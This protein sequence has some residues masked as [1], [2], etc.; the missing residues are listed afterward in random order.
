[1]KLVAGSST[2]GLSGDGGPATSAQIAARVSW[3]DSL[4]NMY[5]PDADNFRI[6]KIDP[7]GIITTFGGNATQSTAGRSGPISSAMFL[8]PWSIVGDTAGSVMFICDQRYVWKYIFATNIIAVYAHSPD[9]PPGMGGDDGLATSAT[10]NSPKRIWLTTSGDLY[11]AD[12]N[13]NRI[14]KVSSVGIITTVAGSGPGG[15]AG[16]FSGDNGPATSATLNR[17]AGVFMD[18]LGKLFITDNNN[19]RVR[20]VDTNLIITTIAG[21]GLSTWNGD[22]F[23]ALSTNLLYPTDVKVDSLG[24]IYIAEATSCAVRRISVSGIVSTVFGS[25]GSC[26]FTP[27][28]SRPTWSKINNLYGVWFDTLYNIYFTDGNAIYKSVNLSPTS[29]PSTQPSRQPSGQPSTHPTQTTYEYMKLIAGSSTNGFG[30]DGGPATSAQLNGRVGLID[31]VGNT[32][33]PDWGNF[34]IRKI[35]AVGIITTFGGNA[36]QSTAGRSGPISSAMFYHPFSIMGDTAGTLLYISDEWR[37]WKYVFVTNIIAVYAHSPGLPPG[38]GGDGGPAISAALNDPKR[39]WL[40]TSG[41][42]YIADFSNNRIRKVSPAGIITTVAGSGASGGA[43]SF[44]GDNSPATLAT[45]NGPGGVFMDSVGKLFI[46]DNINCRIRMVDSNSIITTIAGTG[47]NIWNGD[48]LPALSTN[49]LTPS[50][51]KGDSLGNLYISEVAGCAVRRISVTGIVSTAFGSAGNCGFTPGVSRPTWSKIN[52]PYGV[53]FDTLSNIYFTDANAIYKIVNV[54]PTSQPSRQPTAQPSSQPTRRPSSQPTTLPT[55]VSHYQYMQLVAGTSVGGYTGDNGPASSAQIDVQLPWVDSAGNI[56]IPVSASSVIRKVNGNTGIITTIGGT[57]SS[58]TAGLGGPIETVSFFSPYSIVGDAASTVLYMSDSLYIWK[59]VFATNIMSVFAGRNSTKGFSGD[60]G[61]ASLAM[62]N[63]PRGL[64]LTS[65][66]E[67]YLSDYFNH[68]IRKI[69]PSGIITTVAGTGTAG[70]LGDNGAATSAQLYNPRSVYV[71]STGKIFIAD[72]NN[73]RI[74]LVTVFGG[75]ITTF[76]G[77]GSGAYNGE[78]LPA[79]STNLRTVEDV[80]GDTLGNIYYTEFELCAIRMIDRRRVVTTVFGSAGTCGFSGG[81]S[82]ALS[83]IGN[84]YSLWID[85]QS[86]VY[87]TDIKTIRKGVLPSPTSQP[88]EQPSSQPTSQPSRQPTGQ[89]TGQPTRR[90]STQPTSLPTYISHYQDM[91]LIAGTSVGGYTGDNGPASAAQID[92]RLPWVDSMGNIYFPDGL[93]IR[94][95]NQAS[96]IIA[97]FGGTSTSSTAGVGGPIGSVSFRY[98]YCVVGDTGSTALYISDS[99]YV[100]KYVFSTNI[101]TLF[102]GRNSTQGYSGDNGPASLA[103]I[104]QPMGIWLTSSGDLYIA[105]FNGYRIRKVSSSGIIATVAGSGV[106]GFLGDNGPATLAQFT[107][108]AG[109]YVDTNGKLFIADL[110]NQ[111]IR[112][113]TLSTGLITTFA[114]TGSVTF[115]GESIPALSANLAGPEDVKGDTMGNIYIAEYSNC[116]IRMV[117][118]RRIITT[119]FGIVGSCGFSSGL[120]PLSSSISNPIGLWIDSQSNVYFS[121]YKTIRKSVIPSPTSQPSR[122][123]TSQPTLQPT[124][125]LSGSLSQGIIAYYPFDG[126]TRDQSGNAHNAVVHNTV[127]VNDRNGRSNKAYN[128]DGSSSYVEV[129]N[130]GAFNLGKQFSFSVWVNASAA[131]QMIIFSNS[132]GASGGWF[133][134]NSDVPTPNTFHFAYL[135]AAS[136]SYYNPCQDIRFV[137]NAWN[138]LAI[139][140]N[141]LNT[142]CYLNAVLV[143]S[144]NASAAAVASNGNLPLTIGVRNNGLTQPASAMTKYFRGQLDDIFFYNRSLTVPEIRQLSEFGSPTSQPTN[145]PTRRPSSQPSVQ[146]TMRPSKQPSSFPSSQPTRRPS[147]QPTGKP[148]TQPTNHPTRQPS[149]KPSVQPTVRPSKQPISSPSSQPSSRPSIKPTTQ[150]SKVPT[151]QPSFHPSRIPSS[152]PSVVP[153]KQ[154][155]SFPSSEPSN[156]PSTQPTFRPSSRP[157]MIPSRLPTSQPTD[158]PVSCPSAT[159]SSLPTS[160]PVSIPTSLPSQQPGSLPTTFP[161]LL[162]SSQPTDYPTGQPSGQPSSVPSCFPTRTTS[163][164]SSSSTATSFPSNIV[165]PLGSSPTSRPS[166][167]FISSSSPTWC[168]SVIP[169]DIPSLAPSNPPTLIPTAAPTIVVLSPSSV[170][171]SFPSSQP[172]HFSTRPPSALPSRCPSSSPS[173][174]TVIP[175]PL[176]SMSSTVAP[177]TPHP[178]SLPSSRPSDSPSCLP[179]EQPSVRPTGRPSAQPFPFPSSQPSHFPTQQP[180]SQPTT[181]PTRQPLSSPTAQ[182]SKQPFSR[183]T[184]RPSGQPTSRPSSSRPSSQPTM[185]TFRPTPLL[186]PSISAY[187]TQTNKPTRVPSVRPSFIP[188]VKPT[189]FLSVFPSDGR[190]K[191]SL[192]FLG[193]YLPNTEDNTIPNIYLNEAPLVDSTSFLMFLLIRYLLFQICAF[194]YIIL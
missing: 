141:G 1:M 81:L 15:G 93:R 100:W 160:Q 77:T 40:T 14:R 79:T 98:P 24:N 43:G 48:N 102:A 31:S 161:T 60:N 122:Q 67:L 193:I 162:P 180:L 5:V 29:Q 6:R 27:G 117:D 63:Q 152:Q 182:P 95:I 34:R 35:D 133:L 157:S 153:S 21:T 13:N 128:F 183:P 139:V 137:P 171:S 74:R 69:F 94:K 163:F 54:L 45:L 85:S 188:T 96:G 114:G 168:P 84:G 12:Y 10:L 118:R 18:S 147:R 105:D 101:V 65:S 104:N 47:L 20:L 149:S 2:T 170:P 166:T 151:A 11:I 32:Y 148:S 62:M 66:G 190:F 175:T 44:S 194:G 17:P 57:G 158:Q 169:T 26:G 135:T 192:F 134:E 156:R 91:Q 70:F 55:Y 38:F 126:N 76:A 25:A 50:D 119:A 9:Q 3:V 131:G 33:L 8:Q 167:G 130:A 115:N 145:Q 71:D 19:H 154:P 111:R 110:N 99:L 186:P 75:T 64:W 121:D 132:H 90:P 113:V 28:V 56:Y 89:P 179:S 59:Y 49:L 125:F 88:S 144:G 86:T 129:S 150:P 174:T 53:W 177:T 116:V 39:I 37:I 41:D 136:S 164:P 138:H 58:S 73:N 184:S 82:P 165:S 97:T 176:P 87:F 172:S 36:T 83:P 46:T 123:P 80:K 185:T 30:G 124:S 103:M 78:S 112:L 52:N 42:L 51:V 173:L 61:P 23:P 143:G 142:R 178:S 107:N 4:G 106:A 146:P 187:P 68:R 108:P 155:I 189:Q 140:K 127:L 191:Q 22:N 159:P 181:Q 120:S 92:S 16:S 72:L 7:F 109:V